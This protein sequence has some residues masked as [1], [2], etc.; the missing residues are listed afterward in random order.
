MK[1]KTNGDKNSWITKEI[2]LLKY[3]FGNQRIDSVIGIA[4]EGTS[5][6]R[7]EEMISNSAETKAWKT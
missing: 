3:R 6:D 7:P 4:E 1:N 2:Q 5:E